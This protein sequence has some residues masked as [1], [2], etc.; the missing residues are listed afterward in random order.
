MGPKLREDNCPD[1]GWLTRDNALALLLLAL[2][3][4]VLYLCFTLAQPFLP[5]LVSG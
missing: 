2:T 1:E 5:G 4:I 3:A